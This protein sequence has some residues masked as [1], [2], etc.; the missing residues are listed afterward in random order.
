M[1]SRLYR[2]GIGKQASVYVTI[3]ALK[4]KLEESQRATW[5]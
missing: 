1:G 5:A 4:E 2:L 3:F